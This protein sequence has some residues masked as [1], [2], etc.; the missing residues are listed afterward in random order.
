[1]PSKPWSKSFVHLPYL[2]Y[3]SPVFCIPLIVAHQIMASDVHYSKPL[4][5]ETEADHFS[6][7]ISSDGRINLVLIRTRMPRHRIGI[8]NLATV[9]NVRTIYRVHLPCA[10][11]LAANVWGPQQTTRLLKIA[12]CGIW[13]SF[14]YKM[15]KINTWANALTL[16][17]TTSGT[18]LHDDYDDISVFE[19]E[20]VNVEFDLNN[21]RND[22]N[23][24]DVQY[25]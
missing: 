14:K 5:M 24:T 8:E 2:P 15:V 6:V 17:N 19:L 9:L 25:D 16:L 18:I 22:V 12:P 23:F 13:L 1:M 11:L 3:R 10:H 7:T 20:L 4:R 21:T